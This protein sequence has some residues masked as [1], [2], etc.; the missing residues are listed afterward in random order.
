MWMVGS[1]A[2]LGSKCLRGGAHVDGGV[3]K[4]EPTRGVVQEGRGAADGD[5]DG[6]HTIF[7]Q[8]YGV[9]AV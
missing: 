1:E 6:V 2:K 7:G 9:W 3:A 8:C 4:V 5:M